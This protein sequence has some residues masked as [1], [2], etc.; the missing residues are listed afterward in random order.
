MLY[1]TGRLI[2]KVLN[3]SDTGKVL[4]FYV[5]NKDFLE[6]W[7]MQKEPIF[8]KEEFHRI[9]LERDLQNIQNGSLLRL[10]IFK[11]GNEGRIIGTAAFSNIVRSPFLSCFLGYKMD[12]DEINKGYMTEAL[13][14]G[15]DIMFNNYGLHRIEA[16]IMPKNKR[17][18]RVVEKLD[19][20]N[21][22]TSYKYLKINGKWEDHIHMVLRNKDME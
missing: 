4:D 9:Q 2:L 11:K 14:R 15:I 5:R 10:W 6:E 21:E 18:L 3:G 17:S 16:N 1:E 22:G 8:Y 12:K 20:Y 19:F 7:E 13:K